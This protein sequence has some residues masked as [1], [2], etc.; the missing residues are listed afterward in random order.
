MADLQNL[1]HLLNQICSEI[2]Q[3]RPNFYYSLNPLYSFTSNYL[4][5]LRKTSYL[6][7]INYSQSLENVKT[8][9]NFE[10]KIKD[11]TQT[12]NSLEKQNFFLLKE[13]ET[14]KAEVIKIE[15]ELAAVEQN[16]ERKAIESG[17]DIL[18]EPEPI[19]EDVKNGA[20]RFA[21]RL[22]DSKGEPIPISTLTVDNDIYLKI[23]EIAIY[24]INELAEQFK[25]NNQI[26]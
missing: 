20:Q 25:L 10:T 23:Q 8:L 21:L 12:M 2:L 14:Y 3:L 17:N 18:H 1:I 11:L 16:L 15:N 26:F 6:P 4:S 19:S 7:G 22:T 24:K 13:I 9:N 5:D